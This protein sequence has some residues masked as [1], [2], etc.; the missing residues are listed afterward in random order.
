MYLNI[1]H[2]QL[3][4]IYSSHATGSWGGTVQYPVVRAGDHVRAYKPFAIPLEADCREAA[5]R[6][7]DTWLLRVVGQPRLQLARRDAAY[8][9]HQASSAQLKALKNRFKIDPQSDLTKGQA[10]DL[11]T[12]LNAGQ[13]KHWRA[14]HVAASKAAKEKQALAELKRSRLPLFDKEKVNI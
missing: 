10:M 5:I 11:L 3:L 8:R 2:C 6:A 12:R 1:V 13:L 4:L 7:T 14:A 9:K